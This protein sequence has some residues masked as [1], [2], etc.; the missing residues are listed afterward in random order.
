MMYT[1]YFPVLRK[2][3]QLLCAYNASPLLFN[4]LLAVVVFHPPRI[5]LIGQC[6]ASNKGLGHVHMRS[7]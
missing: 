1:K 7:F 2:Q 6:E 4:M 5:L 3:S